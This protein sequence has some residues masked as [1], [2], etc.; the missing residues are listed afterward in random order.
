MKLS[1]DESTY[2]L[3]TVLLQKYEEDWAPVEYGSQP[4]THS[5]MDS[6]IVWLQ[7]V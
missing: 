3:G 7:Q 6:Y 2:G 1:V 4:L 5:E